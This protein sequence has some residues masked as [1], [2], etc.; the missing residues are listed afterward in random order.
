MTGTD[1][2]TDCDMI[3]M[4]RTRLLGIEGFVVRIGPLNSQWFYSDGDLFSIPDI[5]IYLK[6]RRAKRIL[7][8]PEFWQH[9]YERKM[10]ELLRALHSAGYKVFLKR[11]V[12]NGPMFT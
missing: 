11:N 1:S 8:I 9:I 10:Q 3:I 2:I 6:Q 12:D 4:A 7:L 5:I